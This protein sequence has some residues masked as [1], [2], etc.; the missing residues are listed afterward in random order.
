MSAQQPG[1]RFP[2]YGGDRSWGVIYGEAFDYVTQR[3]TSN[4]EPQGHLMVGGGFTRSLKQGIDQVGRYDD[5]AHPDALTTSHISGILPAIF[6]PSWGKGSAVEQ[7]W[8]GILGMTGDM[9]PLVG[10]LDEG[11]TGRKISNTTKVGEHEPGEWI[12]AGFAGE[13]MV[14]AWLSGMALGIMMAGTE[15]EDLSE[16]PGKPGG[17]LADWFPRELLVTRA[18]I[19]NADVSNLAT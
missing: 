16:V 13:G 14:W 19:L 5:G 17:K 6:S 7:V 4:D 9:L 10:R 12:L 18:R 3:P 15:E 11:L 1:D 2:R 8:S